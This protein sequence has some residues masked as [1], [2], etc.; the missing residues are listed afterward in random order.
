M[1]V[2]EL[3]SHGSQLVELVASQRTVAELNE[4]VERIISV[5]AHTMATTLCVTDLQNFRHQAQRRQFFE[6]LLDRQLSTWLQRWFGQGLYFHH[7]QLVQNQ[8]VLGDCQSHW[9]LLAAQKQQLSQKRALITLRIALQEGVFNL[10][11]QDSRQVK[12]GQIWLLNGLLTSQ[13]QGVF[14]DIKLATSPSVL[15]GL[16]PIEGLPSDKDLPYLSAP[17]LYRQ[18]WQ[19][20]R[21]ASPQ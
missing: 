21:I 1:S 9:P 3:I 2:A 20:W 15:D 12:T 19:A 10:P 6:L 18:A 8:S 5:N 14:V 7:L 4:A 13:Q 17:M 16:I 11:G